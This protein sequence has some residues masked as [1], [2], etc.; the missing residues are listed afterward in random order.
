MRIARRWARPALTK[1]HN[2]GAVRAPG[3][4][5][6]A[7]RA[8]PRE[9]LRSHRHP[10]DGRPWPE[11]QTRSGRARQQHGCLAAPGGIGQPALPVQAARQPRPAANVAGPGL[12][13]RRRRNALRGN[14]GM[15]RHGRHPGGQS[16]ADHL[17]R[18]DQDVWRHGFWQ[19]RTL[20]EI[21]FDQVR[22]RSHGRS[23]GASLSRESGP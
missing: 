16:S 11:R 6:S 23:P 20:P 8:P 4:G 3:G 19:T 9:R 15:H 22:G 1:A 18:F 7:R 10:R 17:C 14:A 12:R 5:A 2:A 21:T 13:R